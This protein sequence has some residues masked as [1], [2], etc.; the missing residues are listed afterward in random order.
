MPRGYYSFGRRARTPNTTY[1]PVPLAEDCPVA[2]YI[3]QTRK[4]EVQKAEE[5]TA[6]N[7]RGAAAYN[8]R[9]MGKVTAR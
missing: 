3:R 9:Q 8:G 7:K 1:D 5:L 4:S 2:A 6:A